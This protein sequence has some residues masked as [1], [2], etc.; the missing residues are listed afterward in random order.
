MKTKICLLNLCRRHQQTCCLGHALKT[1]VGF[2][3][4]VYSVSSSS[5]QVLDSTHPCTLSAPVPSGISARQ[6]RYD[7]IWATSA[8]VFRHFVS[9]CNLT[10]ACSSQTSFPLL[11][12]PTLAETSWR[13]LCFCLHLICCY[14]YRYTVCKIVSVLSPHFVI[15][16]TM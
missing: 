16:Q 1:S 2:H 14:I 15:V 13:K 10:L 7:Q 8:N 9:Q 3:T 4:P 5:I 12:A 6:Y 11:F